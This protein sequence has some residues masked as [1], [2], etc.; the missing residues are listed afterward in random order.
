L[1]PAAVVKLRQLLEGVRVTAVEGDLDA[2]IA[3]V[4]D[5]SRAVAAGDLFIA[6][7]G[8]TVDGHQ[9]LDAAAQKG[10]AAAI[11]ADDAAELARAKF[12]G[13]RVRVAST[14]EAL[15]I[16]AANRFG[17]PADA[18][19][20]IGITGTNGKTT[21]T[22]LCEGL[23]RAAGG[24]PGVIG[25]VTYRWPGVVKAAPFTTPTPLVLH[26]TL[27]EMRAAGVTHVAMEVS[28]HALALD[29][30]AGMKFRVGAFTNL[31]QDHLDFHGTMEAYRDAKALL[32]SAHLRSDGAGVVMIDRDYGRDILAAVAG[33]A[34]SVSAGG[35]SADVR[36]AGVTQSLDGITAEVATPRGNVTIRSHLIGGFNVENLAL[37]VGIGVALELSPAQIGAG[38][39]SVSAVPGRLE[40][41]P[42]DRGLGIFV[43]YAHTPDALERAI[44]AVRGIAQKRL[45]VVFGCGGDRDKTKR[46][47]MGAIAARKADLAVVTSDNPRTEDPRAI[48]D[49]IVEGVKSVVAG[50]FIVEVDRRRAIEI[51]VGEARAGDVVL[52]AGKG[53]EDY[54]IIGTA[55]Q[56]FDDREEAKN[57]LAK[58]ASRAPNGQS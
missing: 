39:S 14:A 8:Q 57:A 56:H 54:Q 41:V 33:R 17:R 58:L 11:V 10:A 31:T 28:S 6:A 35:E 25:T 51:A 38:L 29:R 12:P 13:V 52:I 47:K 5:D 16:V 34:I 3:D 23:V 4:R 36:V 19:T 42:N 15:A 7:R 2:D 40:R 55:K 50:G 1:H 24:T 46:P 30:V 37:A 27:A 43:D 9:F 22:F 20:L 49:M 26:A 53:H 45:I 21:S 32:F 48:V 18:L 44:D